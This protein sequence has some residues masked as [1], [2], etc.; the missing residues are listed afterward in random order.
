MLD[1][2]IT[3][4][5]KSRFSDFSI[6]VHLLL[7]APGNV[8]ANARICTGISKVLGG[9]FDHF[10]TEWLGSSP[11]FRGPE[12]PQLHVIIALR[13]SYSGAH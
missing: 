2:E 3:K 11:R 9:Q 7:A 10:V 4:L 8:R 6:S 1:D 5:R 12:P 13:F